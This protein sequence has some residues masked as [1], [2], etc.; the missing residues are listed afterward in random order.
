VCESEDPNRF[1]PSGWLS[2]CPEESKELSINPSI[3]QSTNQ[4]I[5]Q[6]TNQPTNQPPM[7]QVIMINQATPNPISILV[8]E[9]SVWSR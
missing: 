4:P 3:N 1:N 2:G 6:S 8:S 9:P 5:N 7:H